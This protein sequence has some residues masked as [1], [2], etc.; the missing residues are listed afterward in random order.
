M[1]YIANYYSGCASMLKFGIYLS[2]DKLSSNKIKKFKKVLYKALDFIKD[3]LDFLHNPTSADNLYVSSV[4][5]SSCTS[6]YIPNLR[7][8]PSSNPLPEAGF[9]R[10]LLKE[11]EP[12]ITL[13]IFDDDNKEKVIENFNNCYVS[14]IQ[15]FKINLDEVGNFG[16]QVLYVGPQKNKQLNNIQKLI[17]EHFLSYKV[18]DK[19]ILNRWKPHCTITKHL[20]SKKFF[21]AKILIKKY[22]Q[23]LTAEVKE[24]G[25][26]DVKKPLEVLAVKTLK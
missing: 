8:D 6:L 17:Y 13:L 10:G 4:L 5:K 2:F 16:K 9:A 25:L 11:M 23:P 1:Y 24:I 19:F 21:N 12:H 18:D 3:P 14:S 22:W 20:N 7:S 26:I 15:S